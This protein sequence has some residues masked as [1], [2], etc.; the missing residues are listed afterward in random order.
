M[1]PATCHT[2]GTWVPKKKYASTLQGYAPSPSTKQ[3]LAPRKSLHILELGRFQVV[4]MT[5]QTRLNLRRFPAP[6]E[7]P[8]DM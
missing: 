5:I 6:I 4:P 8:T 1:R 7:S 3:S 2:N